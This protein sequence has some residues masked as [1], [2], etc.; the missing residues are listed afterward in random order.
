[1]KTH[2]DGRAGRDP[3]GGSLSDE[4]RGPRGLPAHL[5]PERQQLRLE[6]AALLAQ[7]L[8]EVRLAAAAQLV[9]PLQVLPVL[10][11]LLLFAAGVGGGEFGELTDLELLVQ[12]TAVAEAVGG[13]I[14]VGLGSLHVSLPN[15]RFWVSPVVVA[16][17]VE[18]VV[19]GTIRKGAEKP[20]LWRKILMVR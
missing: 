4:L 9:G 5:Q 8:V 7:R 6:P 11:E 13:E 19:L 18:P 2:E 14:G 16:V 17:A 20:F 15:G 1:M 12:V 3:R 10:L